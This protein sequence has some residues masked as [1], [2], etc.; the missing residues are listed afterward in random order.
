MISPSGEEKG[1][2]FLLNFRNSTD[3]GRQREKYRR[4][5]SIVKYGVILWKFFNHAGG[6]SIFL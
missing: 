4:K 6:G 5:E 1:V 3:R 2:R